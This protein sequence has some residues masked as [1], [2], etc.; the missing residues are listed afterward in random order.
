MGALFWERLWRVS[1]I[2]FIIGLYPGSKSREVAE[3]HGFK[4]YD[5]AEAVRRANDLGLLAA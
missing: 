1:G 2:N 3:Q 4:V 5:T